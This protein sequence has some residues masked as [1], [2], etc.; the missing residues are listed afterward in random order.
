MR[1][2]RFQSRFL[3]LAPFLV[4]VLSAQGQKPVTV[5]SQIVDGGPWQ[6]TVVMVNTSG[7]SATGSLQFYAETGSAGATTPWN[8]ALS[9]LANPSSFAL[10]PGQSLSVKTPGTGSQTGVG[11]G[12]L[13]ADAAV[14]SYA[15]FTL[16]LPGQPTVEGTAIGTASGNRV[17]VPFDNT[18]GLDTGIGL[19]NVS[20]SAQTVNVKFRTNGGQVYSGTA[21]SVPGLGH[22]AFEVTDLFPALANTQGLAEFSGSGGGAISAL[23]L[24]SIGSAFTALP[25]VSATG[26]A[27]VTGGTSLP[28]VITAFAAAQSSISQ[29]ASTTL[30]WTVAGAATATLDNG[31]GSAAVPSG[32]R[33]ISP[34]QTTTYKLTA[35][36]SDGMSASSTTTVTVTGSAPSTGQ[37]VALGKPT[38]QSGSA[39][40]PNGYMRPSSAAVDGNRDGSYSNGSLTHNGVADT[41]GYWY[42]DLQGSYRI[43]SIRVWGRTDCCQ[44]RLNNATVSILPAGQNPN[45][46]AGAAW[47]DKIGVLPAPTATTQLAGTFTMDTTGQYVRVQVDPNSV[48]WLS[49]AEVEV[50]GTPVSGTIGLPVISSFAPDSASIAAGGSTNLRWTISGA[51]SASIDNGVGT[52]AATTGSVS[53]KPSQTTTYRL[54]ATNANGSTTAATTV[55]TAASTGG[56]GGTVYFV[57]AQVCDPVNPGPCRASGV[58][59]QIEPGLTATLKW[60]A[61]GYTSASISPGPATIPLVG[62]LDVSPAVTTIYTITFQASG[63]Q[64]HIEQLTVQVLPH[65]SITSFSA[66]PQ[67]IAPGQSATLSWATQNSTIVDLDV[68]NYAGQHQSSTKASGSFVVSPTQTTTYT[69]TAGNLQYYYAPPQ[70]G[71]SVVPLMVVPTAKQVTVTVSASGGGTGTGGGTTTGGSPTGSTSSSSTGVRVWYCVN[72]LP[73]FSDTLPWVPL[74]APLDGFDARLY[75]DTNWNTAEVKFRNRYTQDISYQYTVFASSPNLPATRYRNTL[76]AGRAETGSTGA[77]T[78]VNVGVGGNACVVVDSVRFGPNDTGPYYNP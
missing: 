69:L 43:T 4:S 75:F 29:G 40:D 6:T 66:T 8:L 1:V 52:V 57:T 26:A 19:V 70:T 76:P 68:L 38:F 20:S 10:A 25:V 27:I 59:G 21:A 24:R 5:L 28:P 64:P 22:T 71:A 9:G 7:Q 50:I 31:L 12:L 51:T 39:T 2:L 32:S 49:L 33:T 30:N 78:G 46:V 48:G 15:V 16:R 11:W 23:A 37:N 72:G 34:T 55:S 62:S 60:S 58:P 73:K 17:L 77:T 13:V 74:H 42:V 67:T 63:V 53:V 35:T 61:S 18:G 54:T 3:A 45:T 47:S 44:E 36:N 65:A 14:Q 56:G 41:S